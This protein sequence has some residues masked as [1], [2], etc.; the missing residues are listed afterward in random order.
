MRTYDELQ[1]WHY[2]EIER[3]GLKVGDEVWFLD[4]FL[5]EKVVKGTIQKFKIHWTGENIIMVDV[6]YPE[7]HNWRVHESIW[8]SD[9]SGREGTSTD[10]CHGTVYFN[11]VCKTKQEAL[12]IQIA[13]HEKKISQLESNIKYQK[14]KIEKFT[15]DLE[16]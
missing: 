15:K 11:T 14:K 1:S 13:I 4:P 3:S 10:I 16:L 6:E 7:V 9:E 8:V 2:S 5:E 12:K